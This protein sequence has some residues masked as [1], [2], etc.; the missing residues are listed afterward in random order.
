MKTFLTKN[1]IKFTISTLFL[2]LIFRFALSVSL[3]NN[4]MIFVGVFAIIY[5]VLMFFNGNYFGKKDYEYLP[6]YDI[7]FRFHFATYLGYHFI[8]ILWLYYNFQSVFETA[9]SIYWS[10]LIWGIFLMVH[11]IYFLI[12][13]KKSIKNLDKE[14]LFE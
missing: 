4:K 2:T 6:I 11:G 10:A 9:N 3:A 13:R 14:E 7:G 1:L 12:L 5:A 8:S